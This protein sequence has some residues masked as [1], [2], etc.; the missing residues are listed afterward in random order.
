MSKIPKMPM[1]INTPAKP[2]A[3]MK[4]MGNDSEVTQNI[5]QPTEEEK[6]ISRTF[7]QALQPEKTSPKKLQGNEPQGEKSQREKP[8]QTQPQN[9][10]TSS[11]LEAPLPREQKKTK[12]QVKNIK[13]PSQQKNI[14]PKELKKETQDKTKSKLDSNTQ[15]ASPQETPI[16]I[17]L[18]ATNPA[19]NTPIDAPAPTPAKMEITQIKT[20]QVAD[21]IQKASARVLVARGD[22][23]GDVRLRLEMNDSLLPDTQ[24]VAEKSPD[25]GLALTFTSDNPDTQKLLNTLQSGLKQHLAQ[26]QPFPV[27]ISATDTQ[28]LLLFQTD[29]LPQINAGTNTE[30]G[31][32]SASDNPQ[33]KKPDWES[34]EDR[35][36]ENK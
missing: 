21:V 28:G 12:P 24:L 27:H 31:A 19:P 4:P 1:S 8:K 30:A 7:K 15:E 10:K 36:K 3:T 23:A 32:Q 29:T 5:P 26:T 9:K 18:S 14:T 16:G 11:Q 6:E 33:S 20:E 2:N 13:Q 22:G 17:P 35:L 34:V 25:G